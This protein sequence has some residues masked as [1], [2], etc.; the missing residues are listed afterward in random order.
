MSREL[1][2]MSCR[3]RAFPRDIQQSDVTIRFCPVSNCYDIGVTHRCFAR[4]VCPHVL[5]LKQGCHVSATHRGLRSSRQ[6]GPRKSQQDEL[7]ERMSNRLHRDLSSGP[8][9][10]LTH[11]IVLR[12][13]TMEN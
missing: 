1:I 5:F 8:G 6:R 3:Q 12:K 10:A 9:P 13:R 4:A 11:E 7:T 2:Q